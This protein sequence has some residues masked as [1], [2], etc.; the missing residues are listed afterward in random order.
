VILSHFAVGMVYHVKAYGQYGQLTK[1][2]ETACKVLNY[3]LFVNW[4]VVNHRKLGG[5]HLGS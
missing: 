1:R 4:V 5:Q 2:Y 3:A